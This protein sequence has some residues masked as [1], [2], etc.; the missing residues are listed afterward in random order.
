MRM[1][2]GQ[3][4]VDR[5]TLLEPYGLVLAPALLGTAVIVLGLYVPASVHDAVVA[6]ATVLGGGGR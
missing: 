1:L 2:Q 3:P 6:A 4:P 5:P